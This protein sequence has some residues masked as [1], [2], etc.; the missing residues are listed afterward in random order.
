MHLGEPVLSRRR[1]LL[2]QPLDFYELDVV[3]PA[4]QSIVSKHYRNTQ[5]FGCLLF[6][7]RH[8][9][10]TP[11]LT[12]SV[13]ALKEIYV[14]NNNNNKNNVVVVVTRLTWHVVAVGVAMIPGLR[15]RGIIQQVMKQAGDTVSGL[16]G[17]KDKSTWAS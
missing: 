7:S 14:D 10:S 5:W 15:K 3:L 13:K 12:N 4:T 8:G 1:D 17:G 2:E 11:C 16:R 9:I 6:Y